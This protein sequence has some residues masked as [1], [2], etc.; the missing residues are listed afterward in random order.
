MQPPQ[1]LHLTSYFRSS[2]SV[3]TE[4]TAYAFWTLLLEVFLLPTKASCLS[5]WI[6]KQ[7][8]SWKSTIKKLLDWKKNMGTTE[9]EVWMYLQRL[10]R[11]VGSYSLIKVYNTPLVKPNEN[12]RWKKELDTAESRRLA[13][14]IYRRRM[15]FLPTQ[16]NNYAPLSTIQ[17]T[18]VI[19]KESSLSFF[20]PL[21]FVQLPPFHSPFTQFSVWTG[22][23]IWSLAVWKKRPPVTSSFYILFFPKPSLST[24][25]NPP[26]PLPSQFSP[27]P[28][29]PPLPKP[30]SSPA[31]CLN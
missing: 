21:H 2:F 13:E 10:V 15:Y 19:S 24:I 4:M 31:Q 28:P 22:F 20:P 9:Y 14:H 27:L 1:G 7:R 6:L 30:P 3:L 26:P 5:F 25:K 11:N 29:L 18:P 8:S 16:C 17:I 23:T 12:R